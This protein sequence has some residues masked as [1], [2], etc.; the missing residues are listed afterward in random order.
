MLTQPHQP[1]DD[2]SSLRRPST[3]L[4]EKASL[5]TLVPHSSDIDIEDEL[6]REDDDDDDDDDDSN[7]DR[8]PLSHIK[9]RRLLYFGA[10][11]IYSHIHLAHLA[12]LRSK[13]GLLLICRRMTSNR[14]DPRGLCHPPAS[15]STGGLP[16]ILP[17]APDHLP[18]STCR[19][20]R[21]AT[22]PAGSERWTS[23][24]A[25]QSARATVLWYP[26]RGRRS[27]HCIASYISRGR[28]RRGTRA[29][30]SH[31]EGHRLFRYV[32]VPI[33]D[34]QSVASRRIASSI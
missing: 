10:H 33:F 7:A 20:S 8:L 2:G 32:H 29:H 16:Q 18:R 25:P 22:T 4:V 34:L 26:H 11:S 24:G 30:T 6:S 14:R 27:R 31:L 23:Y 19:Q 5:R 12:Q 9:Q 21:P 17:L 13:D 15:L 1:D 3:E 28:R